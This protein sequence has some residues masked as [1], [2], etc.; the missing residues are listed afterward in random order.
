MLLWVR[1]LTKKLGFVAVIT[2]SDNREMVGNAMFL[3][4]VKEAVNIR[5]TLRRKGRRRLL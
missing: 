5:S 3:L 1:D 2:K 4:D